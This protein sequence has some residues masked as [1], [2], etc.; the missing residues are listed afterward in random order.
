MNFDKIRK[1]LNPSKESS[2]TGGS[3]SSDKQSKP[4]KTGF[5]G[6]SISVS[7]AN[8]EESKNIKKNLQSV[9]Q[10]SSEGKKPSGANSPSA[11]VSVTTS[12]KITPFDY[13][14]TSLE[15]SEMTKASRKEKAEAAVKKLGLDKNSKNVFISYIE[16]H[17]PEMHQKCSNALKSGKDVPSSLYASFLGKCKDQGHDISRDSFSTFEAMWSALNNDRLAG[18]WKE[19]SE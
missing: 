2:S 14:D 18:K 4:E 5:F 7:P 3:A 19:E 11:T 15:L 17:D 13:V 9:E 16:E 6:F 10:Q 12:K 8:S 1:F